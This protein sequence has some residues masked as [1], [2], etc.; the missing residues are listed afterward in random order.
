MS[1]PVERVSRSQ[2]IKR[3]SFDMVRYSTTCSWVRVFISALGLQN[4][5]AFVYRDQDMIVGC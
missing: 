2:S 5:A 4:P 3:S 1:M